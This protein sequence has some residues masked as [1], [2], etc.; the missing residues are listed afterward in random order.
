MGSGWVAGVR[1][2][3]RRVAAPRTGRL[4]AASPARAAAFMAHALLLEGHRPLITAPRGAGG[5]AHSRALP[6][7]LLWSY[8]GGGTGEGNRP[9]PGHPC[10]KL[11]ASSSTP[12]LL[13]ALDIPVSGGGCLHCQAFCVGPPQHFHFHHGKQLAVI[14][15]MH[16]IPKDPPPPPPAP[17]LLP[18]SI[19]LGQELSRHLYC[20][21]LSGPFGGGG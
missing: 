13:H 12:R 6:C 18:T 7:P 15:C 16:N 1:D 10:T 3:G 5:M 14:H 21:L 11:T 2:G 20:F 9:L 8:K 17:H 19:Q 4:A